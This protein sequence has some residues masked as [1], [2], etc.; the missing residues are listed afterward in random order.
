MQQPLFTIPSDWV[1]PRLQ[2]LPSWRSASRVAIDTETY[3]PFLKTL[4][5]GVRRGGKLCGVSVAIADGP[6]FYLPIGHAEGNLD[7]SAVMAYLRDNGRNFDGELTGMNLQYDLDYLESEGADFR[8]AKWRDV[9]VAESLL[10]EFRGSCSLDSLAKYYHESGKSEGLLT[11][12]AITAG[13]DAKSHMPDI[14]AKYVAP[15]AIADAALCLRICAKQCELLNAQGLLGVMA[16]EGE[17]QKVLLAMRRRG[18]RLDECRL[19][20]IEKQA[21][22]AIMDSVAVLRSLTGLTLSPDDFSNP[23]KLVKALEHI[24]DVRIPRTA[25]GLPSIDKGFLERQKHP[26]AVAIGKARKWLTLQN[27]FIAGTRAHA[28]G[29]RVYPLLTNSMT[30]KFGG[31]ESGAAFGRLSSTHPNIQNQPSKGEIGKMWRSIYVPDVGC[32]WASIDYSAQEPRLYTHFAATCGLPGAKEFAAKWTANPRMD[33]HSEVATMCGI[34]RD[35]AKI[36]ALGLAYGMGGAKLCKSLKLPTEMAEI[37][38]IVREVPGPEGRALL[39][40]Y[41]Q[42]FPFLQAL[43]RSFTKYAERHGYVTTLLGRRCRFEVASSGQL[44]YTYK[45]LNR[46]IQGSAADQ[47][48]LAMI[49]CHHAGIPLQLQ[50]HDELDLSV[51]SIEDAKHVQR[52]MESCV[53]LSVP[54][55]CDVEVGPNWGMLQVIK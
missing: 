55:I 6:A 54:S 24:P 33:T 34:P 21:Q 10:N 51:H 37:H 39:A 12:Y 8:H 46:V 48:K 19:D 50:V 42:K 43:A 40:K 22:N 14:P 27:T 3:D 11:E 4:G 18:I 35:A 9:Q 36:I 1:A 41:N 23:R 17:V 26:I 20:Q 38:G 47:T 30:S 45:A 31:D 49:E 15:Y 13:I 52:I 2:D 44:L 32:E 53:K 28:I 25:T 5:P 7:R 16:R 29:G